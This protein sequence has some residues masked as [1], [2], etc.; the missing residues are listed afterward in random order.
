M[1][2][3]TRSSFYIFNFLYIQQIHILY[4]M[5]TEIE[6]SSRYL[7]DGDFDKAKDLLLNI[8][9]EDPENLEAL[10]NLGIAYTENGEQEEAITTLDF[11]L[12]LDRSNPDVFEALGCAYYRKKDYDRAE[13]NYLQALSIFPENPSALRNLGVLCSIK[14]EMKRGL[15]YLEESARLNPDDYLTSYALVGM[16]LNFRDHKKAIDMCN[17]LQMVPY[18]PD[19][20]R[21]DIEK[22]L[23]YVQLKWI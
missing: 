23:L 13:S 5:S 22:K 20:I 16:Y 7:K 15:E 2:F 18:L 17:R 14:K 12:K 19:D 1:G 21:R 3:S 9:S 4:I 6:L 11:Y 10:C 8:L